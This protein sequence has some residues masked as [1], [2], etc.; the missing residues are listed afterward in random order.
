MAD[1]D[2]RGLERVAV[3]GD[4]D[5]AARL[6][7]ILLRE[8]GERRWLWAQ[9]REW[10][11][12]PRCGPGSDR[13]HCRVCAGIGRVHN[14]PGKFKT[15][16]VRPLF[17]APHVYESDPVLPVETF[18]RLWG[19]TLC[20][21][22]VVETDVSQ[23]GRRYELRWETDAEIGEQ[24][25]QRCLKRREQPVPDLF[26]LDLWVWQVAWGYAHGH[27]HPEPIADWLLRDCYRQAEENCLEIGCLWLADQDD[28]QADEKKLLC[29][30]IR[31]LAA[32]GLPA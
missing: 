2:H 5:A 20:R 17:F 14:P 28:P 6:R 7:R 3:A 26:G 4:P 10:A 29:E 8:L 19:E 30:K 27:D 12:C 31:T 15:H 1:R 32:L 11:G 16:L 24:A 18:T 13:T 9:R 22:D 21:A 25:C 23:A